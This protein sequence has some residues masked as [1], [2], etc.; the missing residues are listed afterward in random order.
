MSEINPGWQK[1]KRD[2]LLS[3]GTTEVAF[4]CLKAGESPWTVVAD[5]TGVYIRGESPRFVGYT[6]L[7]DFAWIFSD[8]MREYLKLKR[9]RIQLVGDNEIKALK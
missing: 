5:H 6:E 8:A 9:C 1:I 4:L 3:P 7:N 2:S